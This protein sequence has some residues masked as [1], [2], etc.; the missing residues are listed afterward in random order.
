MIYNSIVPFPPPEKNKNKGAPKSSHFNRVFHEINHPF[1]GVYHP[2]FWFNTHNHQP[3]R[4]K[5]V[6]PPCVSPG[7]RL[8]VSKESVYAKRSKPHPPPGGWWHDWAPTSSKW[9]YETLPPKRKKEDVISS[10][11]KCRL[12]E[13]IYIN[14]QEGTWRI[15]PVSKW[16]ISPM[17]IVSPLSGSG[18][19]T[20]SNWPFYGL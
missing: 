13:G 6:S 20:P 16:L 10:T 2:Y 11:Q 7:R 14:S 17:V 18:C 12:R 8:G 3:R 15:I 1:W 19:G 4:L 5:T 9:G